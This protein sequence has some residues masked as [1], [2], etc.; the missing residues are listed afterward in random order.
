MGV[1]NRDQHD[2]I[3][4][5]PGGVA[6]V[7]QM[8]ADFHGRN[9]RVRFPMMMWDQGTRDSGMSWP[10]AVASLTAEIGA[11]GRRY[12]RWRPAGIFTGGRQDGPSGRL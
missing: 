3:R 6:G 9:V 11:D 8:I 4:S 10:D 2:M 5:M 1:D 12:A 7:K